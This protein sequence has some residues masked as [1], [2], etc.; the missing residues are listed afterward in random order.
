MERDIYQELREELLSNDTRR[1]S[2]ALHVLEPMQF[3]FR[4][5]GP[6]E[7]YELGLIPHIQAFLT[8]QRFCC[9]T[10]IVGGRGQS[11][12]GEVRFYAAIVLAEFYERMQSNEPLIL[13]D[14]VR[15]FTHGQAQ[16]IAMQNGTSE[17]EAYRI[18]YDLLREKGWLEII[19]EVNFS[20]QSS[21]WM[22]Y[23]AGW[24][25]DKHISDDID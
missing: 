24:G 2:F 22:L 3:R 25:N 14:V 13:R 20:G 10:P 4:D 5:T 9:L 7:A 11:Y 12:Y 6:L 1:I 19:P 15:P 21:G 17:I 18:S 23:L 16:I 8:D